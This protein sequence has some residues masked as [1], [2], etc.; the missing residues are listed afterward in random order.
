MPRAGKLAQPAYVAVN[1]KMTC[2][3]L[4]PL[5]MADAFAIKPRHLRLNLRKTIGHVAEWLRSGL[6]IRIPRF[7]SGRGLQLLNDL[8]C[9]NGRIF[10]A[11]ESYRGV[12]SGQ[13]PPES[14]AFFRA[15][16]PPPLI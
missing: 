15:P 6:Q 14:R 5:L 2:K 9:P 12:R 16:Q 8:R 7:D 11:V 10:D 4:K 1:P 13:A 3:R